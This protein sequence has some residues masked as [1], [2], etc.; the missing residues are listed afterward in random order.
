M[1][2]PIDCH[3]FHRHLISKFSFT[4]EETKTWIV[5]ALYKL[6]QSSLEPHFSFSKRGG[7]CVLYA[8]R[9]SGLTVRVIQNVNI[10]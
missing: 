7:P 1:L 6:L 4:F 5:G 9:E 2:G 8:N 3:L 10:I